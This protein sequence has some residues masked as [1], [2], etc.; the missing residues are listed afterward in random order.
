MTPEQ[1]E[2]VRSSFAVFYP[3]AYDAFAEDFYQRLF[4]MDPVIEALFP[5]EMKN[6]RLKLMTT[7]NIAVNGLRHPASIAPLLGKLG[8]LHEQ[9]GVQPDHYATLGAALLA[10]LEAQLGAEFT[11][12]VAEAWSAAY[13]VITALMHAEPGPLVA[14]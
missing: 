7:F 14:A 6:Q 5:A 10:T 4:R 13:G 3:S 12:E 1:M 9:A 11:P 8:Q 2:L